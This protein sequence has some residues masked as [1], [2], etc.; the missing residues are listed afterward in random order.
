[1]NTLEEFNTAWLKLQNKWNDAAGKRLIAY[2]EK[3]WIPLKSMFVNAYTKEVP[4]FRNN[5]SSHI[6]G[7]YS[8]LKKYL[9]G[10]TGDLFIVFKRM[11]QVL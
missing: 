9:G 11:D 2:I 3:Q 5:T 1:M 8:A 7:V 6:K 4:H 10:S